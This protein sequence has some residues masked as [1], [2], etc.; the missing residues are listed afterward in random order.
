MNSL[1]LLFKQV[2]IVASVLGSAAVISVVNSGP[3]T[4]FEIAEAAPLTGLTALDASIPLNPVGNEG[5]IAL[6]YNATDRAAL[7]KHFGKFC[8]KSNITISPAILALDGP[9]PLPVKFSNLSNGQW[10]VTQDNGAPNALFLAYFRNTTLMPSKIYPWTA[11][12]LND[13]VPIPIEE[14]G[15]GLVATEALSLP[16]PVGM[17]YP[18]GLIVTAV[19]AG[20]SKQLLGGREWRVLLDV[21]N[22]NLGAATTLTWEGVDGTM[23][24]GQGGT[25][26][27][28][29]T[30]SEVSPGTFQFRISA[31][32]TS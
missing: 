12:L 21:Y 13:K 27:V 30:S 32:L 9:W 2:L 22:F 25:G 11:S 8:Q 24:E 6:G 23:T 7:R 3:A 5:F 19:G 17:L 15:Y 20:S 14:S 31:Y 10:T 16:N 18:G 1:I 29:A 4:Y 28:G 26:V